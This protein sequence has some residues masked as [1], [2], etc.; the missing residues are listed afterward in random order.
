MTKKNLKNWSSC[1][2]HR[3]TG[4]GGQ[5]SG[6]WECNVGMNGSFLP[7]YHPIFS[8]TPRLSKVSQ[9]FAINFDLN[10]TLF[11]KK[12]MCSQQAHLSKN[13]SN[14]GSFFF[15][16]MKAWLSRFSLERIGKILWSNIFN[17]KNRRTLTEK[18]VDHHQNFIGVK[19]WK[20]HSSK[21]SHRHLRKQSQEL[22]EL[23]E[24]KD[25][26]GRGIS[27]NVW[28]NA[29]GCSAPSI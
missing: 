20:C 5:W 23:K 8:P 6:P 19:V 29:S 17:F 15:F 3:V 26:P 2:C 25:W 24:K 27:W 16:S 18:E 9:L 28:E 22:Q 13:R 12:D 14:S 4:H 7:E 10:I 21:N 11:L 1:P